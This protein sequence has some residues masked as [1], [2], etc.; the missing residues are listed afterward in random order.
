MAFSNSRLNNF[1]VIRVGYTRAAIRE[2]DTADANQKFPFFFL[3]FGGGVWGGAAKNGKEIFGFARARYR[4]RPEAHRTPM[5]TL[6]SRI[7]TRSA[8]CSSIAARLE[9]GSRKGQYFC[10]K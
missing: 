9:M 7:T 8:R 6:R 3:P 2:L 5:H 1:E 10:T 4:A